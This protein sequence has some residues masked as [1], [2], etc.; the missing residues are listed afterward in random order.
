MRARPSLLSAAD[1]AEPL[2]AAL[3][4]RPPLLGES[5]SRRAAVLI[6]LHDREGAAR[7]G[8]PPG[9]GGRIGAPGASPSHRRERFRTS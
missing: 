1:V 7:G 6:M 9:P 3:A 2:R 8:G 5:P 4:R